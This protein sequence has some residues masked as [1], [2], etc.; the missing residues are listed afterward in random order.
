MSEA[1][2]AGKE[3]WI[4]QLDEE[5]SGWDDEM[6]EYDF[7]MIPKEFLLSDGKSTEAQNR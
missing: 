3:P 7:A 1:A 2:N 5:I 4:T 6:C